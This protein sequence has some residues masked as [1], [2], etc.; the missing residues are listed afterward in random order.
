MTVTFEASVPPQGDG[1]PQAEPM[2]GC[3]L[4]ACPEQPYEAVLAALRCYRAAAA[5]AAAQ[6][7]EGPAAYRDAVYTALAQLDLKGELY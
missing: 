7:P 4:G 2:I 6:H 3:F 1:S 5:Q